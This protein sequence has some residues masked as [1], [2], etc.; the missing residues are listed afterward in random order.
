[1]AREEGRLDE[2]F[3]QL[4]QSDADVKEKGTAKH[5][6]DAKRKREP[7]A[8]AAQAKPDDGGEKKE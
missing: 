1:M 6:K 5:A 4:T 2:V 3:R 7:E 8:E